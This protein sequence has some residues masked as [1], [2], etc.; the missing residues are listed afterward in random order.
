MLMSAKLFVMI[1]FLFSPGS[2][3]DAVTKVFPD[4]QSCEAGRS[5]FV[6]WVKQ[7]EADFR[8]KGVALGIS[9]C[10]GL[11]LVRP[12]GEKPA[13]ADQQPKGSI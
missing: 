6:D 2:P 9:P 7:N 12:Q 11:D 4:Q 10:I 8:A 5:S 1:A 13:D 3:P